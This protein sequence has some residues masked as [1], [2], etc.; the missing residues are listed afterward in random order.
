V[1]LFTLNGSFVLPLKDTVWINALMY[2]PALV[3]T[4]PHHC[5]LAEPH[6]LPAYSRAAEWLQL[7]LALLQ[8]AGSTPEAVLHG[9]ACGM[10]ACAVLHVW[11]PVMAGM[12]LPMWLLATQELPWR[13][14]F[15]ARR[16]ALRQV[17]T[18]APQAV[19]RD[20]WTPLQGCVIGLT[21]S[22]ALWELM[23]AVAT[24]MLACEPGA[25]Q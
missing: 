1:Y 13:R 2:L 5:Q 8:P 4:A 25:A 11:L 19:P 14:A 6:E 7:L 17:D 9:A 22:L 20:A 15:L 3:A 23:E 16:A 10:R 24:R 12:L 18:S 21:F